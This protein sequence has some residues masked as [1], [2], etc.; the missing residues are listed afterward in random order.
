LKRAILLHPKDGKLRDTLGLALIEYGDLRSARVSL[1]RA[2]DLLPRRQ[3]HSRVTAQ[4][5]AACDQLLKYE[6]SLNAI[7]GGKPMPK[8]PDKLI[9]MA[10]LACRPAKQLYSTSVKLYS[11]AFLI[12]SSLENAQ[13]YNAACAAALAGTGQGK[14][15]DGLNSKQRAEWRKLARNWLTTDMAKHTEQARTDKGRPVVKQ[16]LTHWLKDPDLAAVRDEPSLAKLPEKERE[17]WRKLWG[18]VASLLKKVE[19]K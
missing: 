12:Q 16:Q 18:D 5:I 15:A 11:Q 10:Y 3:R 6:E 1:E 2:L 9:T 7:L 17:Q 4:H 14:D 13:R 8:G 19:K